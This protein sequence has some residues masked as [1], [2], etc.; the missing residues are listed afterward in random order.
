MLRSFFPPTY[1]SLCISAWEFL[2]TYIQ[3]SSLILSMA[4]LSLLMNPF[5]ISVVVFSFLVFLL[6]LS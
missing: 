2:L 5:I 4:L 1:F 3:S 6:I